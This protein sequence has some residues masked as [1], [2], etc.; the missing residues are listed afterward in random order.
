MSDLAYK[1][2]AIGLH[3]FSFEQK[4]KKVLLF[5]EAIDEP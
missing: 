4:F 2:S 3:T 1:F 5:L